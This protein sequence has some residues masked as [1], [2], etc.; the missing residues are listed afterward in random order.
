MQKS[1]I[2]VDKEAG[3]AG[4]NIIND[5]TSHQVPI[6]TAF[7]TNFVESTNNIKRKAE[8]KIDKLITGS[9]YIRREIIKNRHSKSKSSKRNVKGTAGKKNKNIVRS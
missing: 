4:V 9:G 3:K 5:M 8:E 6:E 7:K 1:A 2:T